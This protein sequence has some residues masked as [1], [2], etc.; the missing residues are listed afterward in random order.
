MKTNLATL[1][2]LIS[3]EEE[4]FNK[5]GIQLY[6]NTT[7]TSI[8]ELNG[9]ETVIE[10]CKKSFEET[11]NDFKKSYEKLNKLKTIL[12]EKNNSFKLSDDRTIQTAIISNN[13]ARKYRTTLESFVNQ[14]NSKKRFTEVN[15]SYFEVKKVNFDKK[16]IESI[17]KELD[18]Q[19]EKTD[20]E[21][22]K[23]NSK[24]FTIDL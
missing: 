10:D 21:I 14:K 22:S 20:F 18:E 11:L 15:N 19:I 9:H 24:E 4:K 13:Y 6:S 7:N 16:E 8:I 3:K 17:I 12:Y 23:L 1:M 2:N 5:L